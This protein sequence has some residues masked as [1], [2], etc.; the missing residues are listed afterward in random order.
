MADLPDGEDY[1]K[2]YEG[3]STTLRTWFVAYGVGAPV[4]M[5]NNEK[6]RDA[7]TKSGEARTLAL[8]FLAGVALQVLLAALNKATAWILYSAAGAS[9]KHS[10]KRWYQRWA[11]VISE[12]FWIDLTVDVLTGVAFVMATFKLLRIAMSI[13]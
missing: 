9:K 1:Y 6:V 4:L 7:V 2:V 12:Q 10:A 5:L 11:D 8:F 3:Y 13:E